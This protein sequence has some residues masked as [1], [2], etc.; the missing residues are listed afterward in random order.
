MASLSMGVSLSFLTFRKIFNHENPTFSNSRKFASARDCQYI[1]GIAQLKHSCLL[2]YESLQFTSA[3]HSC[4]QFFKKK[5]FLFSCKALIVLQV[6]TSAAIHTLNQFLLG[7][8]ISMNELF[9]FFRC[10]ATLGKNTSFSLKNFF[11]FT[12]T[13]SFVL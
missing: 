1:Y 5:I 7:V 12:S 4:F 3:I 10:I 11:P 2:M 13:N 9:D 8:K 6:Y